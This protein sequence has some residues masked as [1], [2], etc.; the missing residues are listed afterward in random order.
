MPFQSRSMNGTDIDLV[1]GMLF[2]TRV[3][4]EKDLFFSLNGMLLG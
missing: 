2:E 3:F 1:S 4:M